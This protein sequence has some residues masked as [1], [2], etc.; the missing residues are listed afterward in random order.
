MNKWRLDNTINVISPYCSNVMLNSLSMLRTSSLILGTYMLCKS[1]FREEA[2]EKRRF[3]V[4]SA[5]VLF[6]ALGCLMLGTLIYTLG[7][8]GSPFRTELLTP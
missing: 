3:S 6:S 8:D 1:S 7:T 2:E 5:R 4:I